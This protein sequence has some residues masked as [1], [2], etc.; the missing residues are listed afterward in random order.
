M[1][2]WLFVW[3]TLITVAFLYE[4]KQTNSR[5]H[6]LQVANDLLAAKIKI[7]E[8]NLG[9]IDGG[10]ENT[11]KAAALLTK[12]TLAPLTDDIEKLSQE[13]VSALKCFIK[14]LGD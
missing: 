2:I 3:A 10:L 8:S 9:C 14:G 5:L 1:N 11:S 13:E 12:S 6:K 7:I 4:C